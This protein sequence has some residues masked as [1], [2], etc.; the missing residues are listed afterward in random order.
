MN[1]LVDPALI[2][3]LYEAG[4]AGGQVELVIRGIC[5][6]RPGVP[7]LSETISVKSI[8]GRFL[9]HSRIWCFGNGEA[10]PNW[11]ADVYVSSADWMQRNFDRRVE[12]MLKIENTRPEEHTSELQSL[13]RSSY[14]DFCRKKKT[15][16]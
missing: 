10:R 9:E 7:G 8:V 11:G 15:H 12:Y 14:A 2:D 13:M 6:L 1:S 4:A 16:T 5:C 3:K